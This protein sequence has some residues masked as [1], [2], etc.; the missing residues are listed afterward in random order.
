MESHSMIKN[1]IV[2]VPFPFD[3]FS[4]LKVRPALCLTSEIGI[5]NHIIIAFI[6]SKL[7]IEEL[8]SDFI[9]KKNTT[10][11]M[12]SGLTVDSVI[13]LH[14]IVTI[15]KVLIKRK[16]GSINNSVCETISE[17]V[18]NLLYLIKWKYSQSFSFPDFSHLFK[19]RIF[20]T[21]LSILKIV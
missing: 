20:A 19:L 2:L 6:S 3:D 17:K 7:P 18:Y 10:D 13:R 9:I 5:Y 11:W 14:K 4:S 15:P 12:V 1:S 21:L 16:L 8:D